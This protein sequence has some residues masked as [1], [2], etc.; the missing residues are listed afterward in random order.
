LLTEE[1]T[2]PSDELDDAASATLAPG[3]ADSGRA[4]EASRVAL[5]SLA[6][7][8]PRYNRSTANDARARM[9]E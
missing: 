6:K 8:L 9:L 4:R 2:R 5:A 7:H 3:L 1:R